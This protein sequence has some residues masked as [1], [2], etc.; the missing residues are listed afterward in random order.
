MNIWTLLDSWDYI[1]IKLDLRQFA[2][3]L[4]P[5]QNTLSSNIFQITGRL[6]FAYPKLNSIDSYI[7]LTGNK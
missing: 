5:D 1:Y 3:I 7:V 4:N 2:D 6:L